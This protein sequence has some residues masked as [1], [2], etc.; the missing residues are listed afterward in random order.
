MDGIKSVTQ[1]CKDANEDQVKR[2]GGTPAVRKCSVGMFGNARSGAELLFGRRGR[3]R[4]LATLGVTGGCGA[5]LEH[6]WSETSL[7]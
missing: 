7:T 2:A 3:N 5:M 1:C 4:S 6:Y